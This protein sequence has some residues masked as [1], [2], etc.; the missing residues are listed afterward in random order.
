MTLLVATVHC[1]SKFVVVAA[2]I[3]RETMVSPV[4]YH[5]YASQS[6][7]DAQLSIDQFCNILRLEESYRVPFFQCETFHSNVHGAWRH[8]YGDWRRKITQWSF[9]VID[10]FKIDREVVSTAMNIL[11][12]YL[13]SGVT[14]CSDM[15]SSPRPEYHHI[16][17]SRTFQLAA[18][19]SLYLAMKASDSG[20]DHSLYSRRF[21][22]QSFLDLSR[23][24]FCVGDITSMERTILQA[25]Q[26]KIYPPTPMTAVSYLLRIMPCNQTLG[27]SYDLVRHVLHELA[28]YLTE[29][30]VCLGSVCVAHTPSQVAY[31][32]ILLSME[33]LTPTALPL[34]IRDAFN[35]SVVSISSISGGTILTPNDEAIRSLQEC[36]RNSFWPEML[37]DDCEHAEIGHP[38]S[39]AKDFGLLDL[40][41][42]IGS[43][44]SA[45]A[46]S[47]P[48]TTSD[49]SHL[50][51]QQQHFMPKHRLEGSPVSV[52][53]H[54]A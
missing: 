11:D 50:E 24:Q 48:V 31:A 43:P 33:L 40:S 3:V 51:G 20:D 52:T 47:P 5:T 8:P 19:T 10:H 4:S 37:M 54:Y 44:A 39:M 28:R 25:L 7:S 32:S 45:A 27:R 18:M 36:L 16:V 30:S 46:V 6:N 12:R 13:A 21:R 34:H 2:A 26:W 38:I 41:Y 14:S 22:L 42:I 53:R 29:L 17:D 1:S 35:A 9:K 15:G 23:G 49:Y